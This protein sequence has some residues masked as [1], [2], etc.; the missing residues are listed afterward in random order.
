MHLKRKN[1]VAYSSLKCPALGSKTISIILK[2]QKWSSR[3][4]RLPN[5]TITKLTKEK[6]KRVYLRDWIKRLC[7][8]V[9]IGDKLHLKYLPALKL[10]AW[11]HWWLRNQL[12][13]LGCYLLKVNSKKTTPWFQSPYQAGLTLRNRRK[14]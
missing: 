14:W 7:K 6:S 8:W 11:N 3:L 10:L 1:L 4:T 13:H 2:R 9:L 12:R 5:K